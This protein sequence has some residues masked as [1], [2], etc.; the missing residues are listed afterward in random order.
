VGFIK[1]KFVVECGPNTD[2]RTL[3]LYLNPLKRKVGVL[4]SGGMDSA[5]L[6][7][8][9][10]RLNVEQ[11]F[12]HKITPYTILRKDG[13]C[14]YAQPV[15]DYVHDQFDLPH[16]STEIVGDP[17]LPES[18]QV[19]SGC[20]DVL[21]K[22]NILYLG[23]IEELAIHTIGWRDPIKWTETQDRKYPFRNL[24]KS[25]I[26]DLIYYFEQQALFEL[27]HSCNMPGKCGSCNGCNERQWGFDQLGKTDTGTI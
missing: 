26:V 18:L 21:A 16:V 13:S 24:N 3:N 27:T 12:I 6:Y 19:E 20:N 22:S 23:L 2:K 10:I 11:G 7:Y 1:K 8:L 14:Q 15:I 5:L 4:V 25:H 9:L 17:T